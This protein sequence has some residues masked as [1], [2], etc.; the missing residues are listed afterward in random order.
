MNPTLSLPLPFNPPRTN[1]F[2]E[3]F[4]QNE[5]KTT[6]VNDNIDYCKLII[7]DEAER[8]GLN[9]IEQLREIYDKSNVGLIFIGMKGLEK[10]LSR[11]PQLYSRIGFSHHYKPLSKE[12]MHFLLS[13]YWEKLGLRI[14]PNDYADFEA[15]SAIAHITNGNFRLID[16]LFRQIQRIIKINNLSYVS[17]EVVESARQCLV[18]GTY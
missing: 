9:G 14:N 5:S 15:I 8:L 11:Y 16:R 13:K 7:I 12:E 17:A 4:L 6:S 2:I 1:S 18:I 10:K 3:K